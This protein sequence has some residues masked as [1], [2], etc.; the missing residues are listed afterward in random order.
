MDI[1]LAGENGKSRF[2][3]E[4]YR[5]GGKT[6]MDIYLAGGISGNL[7]PLWTKIADGGG[8]YED[9]LGR[10]ASSEEW[11]SCHRGGQKILESFYYARD[12][13]VIQ[14]LI[15]E[16]G[17]FLLDSGAFSFVQ[18]KKAVDWDK[19][20]EEYAKFINDFNID[21]FLELDIDRLIGLKEVERLRGKLES[22][23]GKQCIPVWHPPR[24]Y[25]YFKQMCRDYRYVA[26]GAFI[27]DNVPLALNEKVAPTFIEE[28][29][30]QGCRIHGLGY[31]SIAGLKRLHFD[32]VDSTAWLY[33]N[34]GGYLY[35][36]NPLT[37]DMD[38][39]PTPPGH[40][41]VAREA[42]KWNFIEWIKFQE[43]AEKYL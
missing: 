17:G 2:L 28:A 42:A 8:Q 15:P 26:Y 33:G 11:Q 25:D 40:R 38:K 35:R 22:L 41:L 7:R 14:K 3:W 32:S 1:Y 23:T 19:Y 6:D 29:H 10:G 36:F 39:I 13:K 18:G 21:L 4:I 34:R 27:T 5:G 43:Y 12:N 9:I 37:G 31:T 24:G 30:S 16:L 20:T